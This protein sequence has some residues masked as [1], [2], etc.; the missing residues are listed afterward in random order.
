MKRQRSAQ[1][2]RW[3]QKPAVWRR[4]SLGVSPRSSRERPFGFWAATV[5]LHAAVLWAIPP[6]E[7]A[8]QKVKPRP[9]V[10]ERIEAATPK[11]P[12]PP[13]PTAV[14]APG[15]PAA[16]KPRTVTR[17]PRIVEAP[18]PTPPQ[19]AD[20]APPQKRVG[21]SLS[22]TAQ[23]GGAAFR[24]GETLLGTTA[25]ASVPTPMAPVTQG[26]SSSAG[27]AAAAVWELPRRVRPIEPIYPDE[28][29]GQGIEGQVTLALRIDPDGSIGAVE[30]VTPSP[31]PAF[32]RSAVATAKREQF[33][34]ATRDGVPVRHT[35][36]CTYHFKLSS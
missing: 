12:T 1:R 20:P 6:S 28:Y 22:A 35:I 7:A 14:E 25:R 9:I 15:R 29:R 26:R 30:L 2:R 3:A 31:H 11:A 13:A 10:V 18:A 32:N 8:R 33:A 21:L 27:P 23:G 17:R 36:R 16:P 5:L 34:P 19:V 24:V 4:P